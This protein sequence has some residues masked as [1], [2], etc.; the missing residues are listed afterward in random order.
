MEELEALTRALALEGGLALPLPPLRAKPQLL[1]EAEAAGAAGAAS[2][3]RAA[4]AASWAEGF[5][6]W[7]RAQE[8]PCPLV[9]D[10]SGLV[11][12]F[13]RAPRGAAEG[14]GAGAVQQ[15]APQPGPG[16]AGAGSA[17]EELAL[18]RSLLT[19]IAQP[20]GAAGQ[21]AGADVEGLGGGGAGGAGPGRAAGEEGEDDFHTAELL[22]L[23]ASGRPVEEKSA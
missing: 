8:L 2:P 3:A 4:A 10:A 12:P 21:E 13:A 6:A 7:E 1:E 9:N 5:E 19:A 16:L 23:L 18:I 20:Q 14:E 22:A 17:E 11:A 15:A